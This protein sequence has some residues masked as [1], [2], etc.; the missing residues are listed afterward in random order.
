MRELVKPSE[1][2]AYRRHQ[3]LYKTKGGG[4]AKQRQYTKGYN[5]ARRGGAGGYASHQ[6]GLRG[7]GG[8]AA[9]KAGL[10]SAGDS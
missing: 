9:H 4:T 3:T 10:R 1:A 8:Y 2:G 7:V 6:A 5:A